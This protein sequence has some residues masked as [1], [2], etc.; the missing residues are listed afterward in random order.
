MLAG[1]G[2]FAGGGAFAAGVSGGGEGVGSS[3]VV[4]GETATRAGVALLAG[5]SRGVAEAFGV[6]PGVTL[7]IALGVALAVTVGSG[8]GVRDA[9]GIGVAEEA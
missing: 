8:F 9:V 6:A 7:G 2:V 5:R 3:G 4:F 1:A